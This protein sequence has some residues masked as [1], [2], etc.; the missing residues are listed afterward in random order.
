MPE[1]KLPTDMYLVSYRRF[2]G[3]PQ[4]E[5]DYE[6]RGTAEISRR[7]LEDKGYTATV[8]PYRRPTRPKINGLSHAQLEAACAELH[9]EE[10]R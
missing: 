9:R 6:S 3:A 2:G 7:R 1:G 5:G 8:T 10:A 4:I